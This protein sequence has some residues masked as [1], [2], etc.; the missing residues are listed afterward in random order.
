MSLRKESLQDKKAI[1]LQIKNGGRMQAMQL[2]NLCNLNEN[3]ALLELLE[4]P[5]PVPAEN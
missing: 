2:K 4:I 3:K 1:L 5:V